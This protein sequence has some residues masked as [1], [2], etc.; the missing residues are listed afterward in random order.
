MFTVSNPQ[1]FA[2]NVT[3][4]NTS[5]VKVDVY[6]WTKATPF[7]GSVRPTTGAVTSDFVTGQR[8]T[9]S[10]SFLA[11]DSKVIYPGVELR[12][13]CGFNYGSGPIELIPVGQFPLTATDIDISPSVDIAVSPAD[14]W[15]WIIASSFLSPWTAPAGQ[16]I[17][18]LLTQLVLDT[19]MW[20]TATITNTI[21]STALAVAQTFDQDRSQAISDLCKVIGAEAFVSR[22]GQF[23]LQDRQ[24]AGTSLLTVR[25]GNGGRLI[26][27]KVTTDTSVVQNV[28]TIVPAN[29][30]PAFYIP[31]VVVRIL[32]PNHPAYPRPGRVL[33]RPYRLDSA[34]F[35]SVAQAT[36]SAQ[37]ILTKISAPAEV[38]TFTCHPDV[39]LDV[40]DTITVV[41]PVTNVS[42]RVQ[43]QQIT[44]PLNVADD[45]QVTTVS[46]R[47]DEDFRP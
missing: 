43:I 4:S 17:K 15:Q 11:S 7:L 36:A 14:K 22:T 25:G 46:T 39:S 24:A 18:S 37:K 27:G 32:D 30:D 20:T 9:L 1:L 8:F 23:I 41:N 34:Q 5:V 28:V 31:P 29:T 3:G 47:T 2:L 6:D 21:T 44:Y 10:A 26:G 42:K 33:T 13:F 45:Q 40:G 38:Q 35:T 12:P 16:P 19:G